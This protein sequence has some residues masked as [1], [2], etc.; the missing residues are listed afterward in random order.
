MIIYIIDSF[1]YFRNVFK[2]VHIG[3]WDNRANWFNTIKKTNLK[4]INNTPTVKLTDNDRYIIFDLL[5]GHYRNSTIQSWQEA[6]VLIGAISSNI[7]STS[8]DEFIK[9]KIDVATGKW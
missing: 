4:W 8:I 3:R 6:G 9:S 2:R 1:F 5:K 7:N